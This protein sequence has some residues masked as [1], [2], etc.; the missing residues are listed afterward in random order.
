MVPS[1]P[2]HGANIINRPIEL[3]AFNRANIIAAVPATLASCQPDSP[4]G[5]G[6]FYH[7][8]TASRLKSSVYFLLVRFSVVISHLVMAFYSLNSVSGCTDHFK[9]RPDSL[10]AYG[11][12][13]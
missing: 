11:R 9:H 5:G 8:A 13:Q 12:T 1:G 7:S 4:F 3:K 10:T 6:F 2:L